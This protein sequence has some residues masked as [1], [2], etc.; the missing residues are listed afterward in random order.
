M[1]C[2]LCS[3]CDVLRR[4]A[5]TE[6]LNIYCSGSL[7]ERAGVSMQSKKKKKEPVGS[8]PRAVIETQ[9]T[10]V[11]KQT[12]EKRIFRIRRISVTPPVMK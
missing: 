11:T 3:C 6:A 2:F 1:A 5:K 9:D 12:H 4:W 7:C 10:T 8:F